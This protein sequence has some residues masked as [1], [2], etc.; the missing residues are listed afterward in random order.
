MKKIKLLEL[1]LNNFKGI[2]EFSLF[3]EGKDS[4]IFGK[5]GAGKTTIFDA[6][7]WVLRGKNSK[8]KKDFNIKKLNSDGSEQN[9]LTHTV[10]AKLWVDGEI[11]TLKREF[12]ERWTKKRGELN[13]TFSGHT[14]KYYID[15]VPMAQKEFDKQVE[16][17]IPEEIFKLL[18]NPTYFNEHMDWKKRRDVLLEVAGDVSEEEVL[19][20]DKKLQKLADQLGGKTVEEHKKRVASQKAKINEQI[21][22]IPARVD[23]VNLSIP[24]LTGL[25][26]DE[27]T[28][29]LADLEKKAEEI[30]EEKHLIQ[31]GA[32]GTALKN[33]L[34][35][36]KGQLIEI[37]NKHR[38][39]N[40]GQVQA[41]KRAVA[42]AEDSLFDAERQSKNNLS[43]LKQA[44][45]SKAEAE[46]LRA[47]IGQKYIDAFN[48]Q[49]NFDTDTHCSLCGQ[50]LPEDRREEQREKAEAKFKLEK[51]EAVKDLKE[52]GTRAK[53]LIERHEAS[54]KELK[55]KDAVLQNLIAEARNEARKLRES[56]AEAEL[57]TTDISKNP[58][59]IKVKEAIADK[60][61]EIE[62]IDASKESK[63]QKITERM[64]ESTVMRD[65]V[66]SNLDKF[67]T[68]ERAKA[69]IAELEE[70][71]KSLSDEF[72]KL[73]EQVYLA[74]E[75][76][77]LK[78]NMLED[79]IA[80]K[81]KEARFK[82]FEEQI[83]GGLKETC[84][85]LFEGVPY[86]SDLNSAA[87]INVGLDII[88]T[89]SE[90]YGMSAPIFIDNA[91]SITDIAEIDAQVIQLVV[92]KK[93]KTLRTEVE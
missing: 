87:R 68:A 53:V 70:Q 42:E 16:E 19:Q 54:V 73:S 35:E 41:A 27:L 59:Y 48:A 28:K 74:E 29:E 47:E 25:D 63:L 24:D 75:F 1:H 44:E 26:K 32:T 51:A 60:Q 9:R 14:T 17:I 80:S 39:E 46:S 5:N 93:D 15:D 40:Y 12:K 2:K 7:T 49:F 66:V 88:D 18:T 76:T 86:G 33:E 6:F 38:Q 78:V 56:V 64:L 55:E 50:E 67:T 85:T 77:R 58:E 45:S 91:E 34:M 3:A 69:R 71:H 72:E 61:A 23:E 4:G 92:S 90:H 81:F 21:D 8:D 37:E 22:L 30:R 20:S 62:N 11:I 10:A 57:L 79:K 83:N 13:E 36:L 31:N 89:L 65:D 43:A 82:L 84:E 52:Q